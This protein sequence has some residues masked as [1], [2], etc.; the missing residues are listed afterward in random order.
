MKYSVVS[1][2]EKLVVGVSARTKNSAPDMSQVIGG[3]WQDFYQKGI[4]PAI[5]HKV[6]DKVSIGLYD[7]Y[8]SDMNGAYDVT[9]G[10]EVNE[11]SGQLP[12][13]CVLKKIPAGEYA[14]F[15]IEGDVQKAVAAF[16]AELWKMPLK[17]SYKADF[18]EYV[19][20]TREQCKIKIYIGLK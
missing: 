12:E 18:E 3:L 17:R 15:E 5:D 10:A 9:V 20:G 14:V 7:A 4:E 16:W 6:K 11:V 19:G 8:E 2:K 13:G 1:L